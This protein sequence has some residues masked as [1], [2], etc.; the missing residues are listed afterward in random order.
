MGRERASAMRRISSLG[1][2]RKWMNTILCGGGVCGG[3][4]VVRYIVVGCIDRA[5]VGWSGWS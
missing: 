1:R 4:E 2:R 5:R 3:A